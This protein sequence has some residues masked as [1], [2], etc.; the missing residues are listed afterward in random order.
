MPDETPPLDLSQLELALNVGLGDGL[1]GGDFA[2]RLQSAFS[3]GESMEG[4]FSLADLDQQPRAIHRP[5]PILDTNLRR[6]VP[7]EVNILFVVNADG[8]VENPIV[9]GSSDPDFERV[10]LNAVRQW[11]FEP[12]KRNGQPVRFRMRVPIKF[13]K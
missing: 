7:A 4:L 9:Q 5:S 1:S 6:K 13:Q 12:G 11:R 10:A 3:S 2:V 8:L